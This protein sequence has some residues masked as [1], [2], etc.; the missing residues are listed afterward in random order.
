MKILALDSSANP[1]ASFS[2]EYVKKVTEALKAKNP[3]AE[4]I[5][6]DLV[7][8]PVSHL[9]PLSVGAGFTP[10]E[11]RTPE[12]K[13]AIKHSDQLVDELLGADVTVIGSPMYNFSVPA[14]LKAWI[15][16]IVRANR[17]FAYGEHGP[18]GL[19]P[20]DKKVILVVSS[21]GVYSS[22][23]AAAVDHNEKYLRGLFGFLGVKN[24]ETIRLEGTAMGEDAVKAARASADQAIAKL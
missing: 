24:I 12:Q 2:R 19:I 1:Q 20:S 15:D 8:T 9:T 16:Q 13:E 17:T 5:Y 4:V 23:P 3:G 18:K 11:S 6:R 21:G 22:G 7:K 14:T 10:A